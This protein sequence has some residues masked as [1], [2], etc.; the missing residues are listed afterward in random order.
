MFHGIK[1]AT[2]EVRKV[3]T[4]CPPPLGTTVFSGWFSRWAVFG[5]WSSTV[6]Q[7]SSGLALHI[8]RIPSVRVR[9]LVS[10]GKWNKPFEW[11]ICFTLIT[12]HA[13]IQCM[14]L[15]LPII[16]PV[17]SSPL[18][19]DIWALD[20][21]EAPEQPCNSRPNFSISEGACFDFPQISVFTCCILAS[22]LWS[23]L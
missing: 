9:I 20:F 7:G 16:V 8:A 17:Y 15:S 19:L 4:A 10:V 5:T 23:F 12:S 1:W 3:F 13:G 11:C 18:N 14:G 21:W 22:L 6:L 2:V